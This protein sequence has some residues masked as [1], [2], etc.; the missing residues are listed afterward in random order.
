MFSAILFD[1]DLSNPE[2]LREARDTLDSL[3]L[4]A[5]A[6][7]ATGFD[8]SGSSFKEDYSPD[9]LTSAPDTSASASGETDL[10]SLSNDLSHLDLSH[11]IAESTPQDWEKLETLDETTKATILGEIFPSLSQFTISHTLRKYQFQWKQTLDDLLNQAYFSDNNVHEEEH[12]VPKGIDA[13]SEDHIVRRGRKGK[14]RPKYL[15]VDDTRRSSSLPSDTV[16]APPTANR[17]QVA[18]K[19]INFIASCLRVPN[20]IVSPI[21][22]KHNGSMSKTIATLLKDFLEKQTQAV[23][24]DPN[25]QINAFELGQEFPDISSNYLTALITLT[26]PS[27]SAAH[28]LAVALTDKSTRNAGSDPLRIVPRYAPLSISDDEDYSPQATSRGHDASVSTVGFAAASNAAITHITARQA[29]MA[30]ARAAY[31]KSKSDHLMGGAAAYYSQVGREHA[32]SSRQYVAAAADALV[33]SQSTASEIDLHGVKLEDAVRIARRRVHA[34]WDGLGESKVN[35][36][37]GAGDRARGF[38]IVTGV[39][40]HSQGGRGVLGP[41][42]TK[43]LKEDGWKYEAGSGVIVV[44]GKTRS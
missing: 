35:G 7:E 18:S 15:N 24:D 9:H 20:K 23:S 32:E 17:W 8:P 19:D 41:G 13:F 29:A 4:T 37:L 33:T 25:I 42:V 14:K 6:E 26:H 5:F 30:Q 11:T 10:T 34:W 28:D 40:R 22:N 36:R 2:S 3:K 44:T 38:R 43:M 31:R 21:Y 1:Y 27:T 12:G 39:G 16:D